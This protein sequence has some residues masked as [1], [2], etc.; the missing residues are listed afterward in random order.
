[1][2]RLGHNKKRKEKHGQS[3]INSNKFFGR[4]SI[5]EVLILKNLSKFI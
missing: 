1:M 2:K 4:Q 5:I 3:N